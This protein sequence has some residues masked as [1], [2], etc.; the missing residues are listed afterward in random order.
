MYIKLYFWWV[1]YQASLIK[2]GYVYLLCHNCYLILPQYWTLS[3]MWLVIIF[4][5][6]LCDNYSFCVCVCTS[7][8]TCVQTCFTG[9]TRHSA[10]APAPATALSTKVIARLTST[11]SSL[12]SRRA[13][14]TYWGDFTSPPYP[15]PWRMSPDTAHACWLRPP[16]YWWQPDPVDERPSSSQF[17]SKT[18]FSSIFFSLILVTQMI[19]NRVVL[20]ACPGDFSL[21]STLHVYIYKTLRCVDV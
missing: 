18:L 2:L 14:P 9:V 12:A 11:S 13:R 19:G 5:I 20:S 1:V 6:F 4:M 7:M 21:W 3:Y 10:P 15:R 16:G 8:R 17:D